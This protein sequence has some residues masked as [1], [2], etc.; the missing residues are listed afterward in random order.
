MTSTTNRSQHIQPNIQTNIWRQLLFFAPFE[1]CPLDQNWIVWHTGECAARHR[2][3]IGK[4][5]RI[6][7]YV[8]PTWIVWNEPF[9]PQ[10]LRS[11]ITISFYYSLAPS[12]S[13]PTLGFSL[14]FFFKFS[15]S[16]VLTMGLLLWLSVYTHGTDPTFMIH[17][18]QLGT[19]SPPPRWCASHFS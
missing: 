5:V 17:M 15:V 9:F 19:N 3:H 11:A 4:R 8:Q 7:S 14:F 18:F 6:G 2:V 16:Y 13:L 10:L 1:P 12:L